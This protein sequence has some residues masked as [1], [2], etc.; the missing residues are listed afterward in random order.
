VFGGTTERRSLVLIK[1]NRL[2][3]VYYDNLKRRIQAH[4]EYSLDVGE[5]IRFP[6]I[7]VTPTR[8]FSIHSYL[9]VGK[10]F[11]T[12]ILVNE[13]NQITEEMD[14][15]IFIKNFIPFKRIEVAETGSQIIVEILRKE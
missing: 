12:S 7:A 10:I 14:L 8:L 15:N 11:L 3:I 2:I 4:W 1:S 5:R 6:Y 13:R 9:N